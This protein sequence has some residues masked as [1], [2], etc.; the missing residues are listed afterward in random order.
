MKDMPGGRLMSSYGIGKTV[1]LE[2]EEAR[3]KVVEALKEQGFGVLTEIDVKRTLK[4]KLDAEFRK[5]VILGACNPPLAHRALQAEEDIG[6]L[7][8]CNV[9]VYEAGSGQSKVSALDP[10]MMV[11]VTGSE[12]LKGIAKEARERLEKALESLPSAE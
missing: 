1:P 5:Y 7:L 11:G 3:A 10:G 2:Y 6:L 4:E 9:I 8:P 12:A